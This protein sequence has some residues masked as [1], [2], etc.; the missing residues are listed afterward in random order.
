MKAEESSAAES[1]SRETEGTSWND[2]R[3]KLGIGD[4]CLSGPGA[5]LFRGIWNRFLDECSFHGYTEIIAVGDGPV[6]REGISGA[7][8]CHSE[9]YRAFLWEDFPGEE[10]EDWMQKVSQDLERF[11]FQINVPFRTVREEGN[12]RGPRWRLDIWLPV[13]QE[14]R[15]LCRIACAGQE[16]KRNL[17]QGTV[18]GIEGEKLFLAVTENGFDQKGGIKIPSVLMPYVMAEK[19]P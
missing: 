6:Q 13:E 17:W 12:H 19:F 7:C 5:K 1:V 10:A 9:G 8:I 15:E 18:A 14:Y 3:K 11:L 2:V 16:E 4:G